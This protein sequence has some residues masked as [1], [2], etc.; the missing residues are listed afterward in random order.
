MRSL[1]DSLITPDL[2]PRTL[3]EQ[4]SNHIPPSL[5]RRISRPVR[6]TSPASRDGCAS[7]RRSSSSKPLPPDRLELPHSLLHHLGDGC[8]D[9]RCGPRYGPP[10]PG[11]LLRSRRYSSGTARRSTRRLSILAERGDAQDAVQDAF[12]IALQRPADLR[13]PAAA[14]AW[15]HAVVR[16]ACRMRL[17]ASRETPSEILVVDRGGE[18]DPE[19]A[20]ERLALRDWVWTALE[21]LPE[22]LRA[23]IMLRYF[24]RGCSYADIGAVLGISI[25]TV[26]SRL[27][28][29]KRPRAA[30]SQLSSLGGES[31]GW[32]SRRLASISRCSCWGIPRRESRPRDA[33]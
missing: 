15:L 28:Q 5:A 9:Q 6:R 17:R 31:A 19:D 18:L 16:N 11:T 29:A 20:L 4:C 8:R 7:G 10:G 24:I 22:S 23:T 12:L 33:P 14:A 26:R 3:K 32:A 21:R 2:S 25:G 27:N 1:A 30:S 13:E